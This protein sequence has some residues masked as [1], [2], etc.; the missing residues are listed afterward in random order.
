[1]RTD[2]AEQADDLLRSDVEFLARY[3]FQLVFCIFEIGVFLRC[4]RHIVAPSKLIVEPAG[5]GGPEMRTHLVVW[6]ETDT[7]QTFADVSVQVGKKI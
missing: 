2:G 1:M 6:L 3:C 5:E 7:L 4:F